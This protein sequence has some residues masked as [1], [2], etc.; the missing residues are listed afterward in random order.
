MALTILKQE[1]ILHSA[2]QN[3]S[4]LALGLIKILSVMD[5]AA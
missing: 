5:I 4:T 3:R 1:V 2:Q